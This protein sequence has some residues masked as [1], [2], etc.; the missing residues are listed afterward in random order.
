MLAT[1]A[2]YL[3]TPLAGASST[4]TAH[5]T[6][7]TG[8]VHALDC[9]GDSPV[10]KIFRPMNCTDIKGLVGVDNANTWGAK[11]YDNGVYIGHDEPDATFLSNT[12]G[13]G[14][15]VT[16]GL[17]LGKDPA[18]L[19]TTA[20]P[21]KDVS[22]WFELSPAPWLSMAMCDNQSYP[23]LNCTPDSNA[24]APAPCK[25]ALKC[26]PNAYPGGGSA[27]MEMQFYPPGNAPFYDNES[28]DNSHWCAALTID[29]LECTQG[30]AVCNPNCEEPVNFA[31]IQT[32][33]VP[34][35]QGGV[36]DNKTLFMN[37][38]DKVS[39]HLSDA[40]VPGGAGHAFKVVI[41][42]L[43]THQNGSMQASARNGFVHTSIASCSQTPYNF[44][45]EDSTAGPGEIIPWA[46]LAT[47][48][49][50]EFE[51]GHFE[52]C[53]TLTKEFATNPFDPGDTGGTY[54]GCVGPYE[55]AQ[56]KGEGP[57]AGDA[58]CYAAG[59][60]HPGYLGK[61]TSSP[62]NEVTGCQDNVFE[63][64]DLDF[65]GTPYWT[66]WP[67]GTTP[68]VNPST[69]V[70]ALPTTNGQTYPQYF[71]QSDVALSESTCS[72]STVSKCTVPP[73]G[74]GH[75]YP[76]WSEVPTSKGAC[77]LE[78]GN[79]TKGTRLN[80]F[81]K[82]KQYGTVQFVKLGYPEFEGNVLSHKCTEIGRAHV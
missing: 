53:T 18:A 20:K 80:D 13:S 69:F 60:T 4:A 28:C 9:N 5:G 49:S 2:V 50:T 44:E 15:N 38:G 33:G 74:P 77:A 32:D 23:Q 67:T 56:T 75:F 65:D 47:N 70:E 71:F 45:P 14:N 52:P 58:L 68:G 31:F 61:G 24:N 82:D 19:P 29:S 48:V 21:G 41:D 10:Q 35:P 7:A 12:K 79:V 81:S 26:N 3:A 63:N 57:E 72:P 62:P 27:F 73:S 6:Q 78:F 66:E 37:P 8:A 64:G 16:W 11:F 39:V 36:P 59:D 51:T 43:T 25:V 22:H 30:F 17:K 55:S 34:D 46:A 42:D 76:F 40:A 54:N 1:L